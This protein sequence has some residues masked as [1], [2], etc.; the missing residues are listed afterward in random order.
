MAVK[1]YAPKKI[2][3]SWSPPGTTIQPSGFM[4]GTFVEVEFAEDAVTVHT[5]ADG[6]I[7]LV[8]N[9]SRLAYVTITLAQTSPD[10]AKLSAQVADPDANRL[11][12]GT[13]NMK[14]LNGNTLVSGTDAFIVKTAKIDFGKSITGRAWKIGIPVATINV[15]QGGD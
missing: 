14:D 3:L 5:G 10:N 15:G 2:T 9:G 12:T 7:S 4:D 13:F 8:L 6:T 1:K 11:P